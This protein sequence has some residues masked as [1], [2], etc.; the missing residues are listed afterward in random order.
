[1]VFRLILHFEAHSIYLLIAKGLK[2]DH[3]KDA[4]CAQY[5]CYIIAKITHIHAFTKI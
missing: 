4:L 3:W 5:Q 1:M 2:L